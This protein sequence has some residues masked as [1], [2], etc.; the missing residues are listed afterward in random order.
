MNQPLFNFSERLRRSS[1]K[2]IREQEEKQDL[3]LISRK[4]SAQ[5]TVE[6]MPPPPK[7][8]KSLC[9]VKQGE[10]CREIILITFMGFQDKDLAT[11]N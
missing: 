3:I 7:K 6:W 8:K 11:R 4:D 1:W 5:S 2:R 9:S 10:N